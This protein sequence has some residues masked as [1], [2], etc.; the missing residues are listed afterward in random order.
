MS[1]SEL[2]Q[3]QPSPVMPAKASPKKEPDSK[4]PPPIQPPVT[5]AARGFILVVSLALSVSLLLYLRNFHFS[6]PATSYTLCSPLGTKQIYTVD[7]DDSRVEC[8]AVSGDLI[9]ETGAHGM[10]HEPINLFKTP[11][12]AHFPQP[13]SQAGIHHPD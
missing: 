4:R 12:V 11:F 9:I 10:S 8:M 3:R 7:H 5:T 6:S 1:E 13:T 2:R